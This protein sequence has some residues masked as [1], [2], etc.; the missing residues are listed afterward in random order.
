MSRL[1]YIQKS[2][3]SFQQFF[4]DLNDVDKKIQKYINTLSKIT[5]KFH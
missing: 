5:I 1:K 2:L 4:W 3:N